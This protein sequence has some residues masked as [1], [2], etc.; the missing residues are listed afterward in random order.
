MAFCPVCKGTMAPL[1]A[2]CPHCGYNFPPEPTLPNSDTISSQFDIRL[3]FYLM[4]L[5]AFV[6]TV[7]RLLDHDSWLLVIPMYLCG[8][9][10]WRTRKV[11]YAALPGLTIGFVVGVALTLSRDPIV[12]IWGGIWIGTTI[13]CPIN[14]WL[15]GFPRWG[16][17][18]LVLGIG[19][20]WIAAMISQ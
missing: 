4:G 1:E 9:L 13:G 6:C 19:S 18:T 12:R 16:C 14:A 2:V 20:M 11:R 5:T 8:F 3:L 17:L 7:C 10:I 15:K